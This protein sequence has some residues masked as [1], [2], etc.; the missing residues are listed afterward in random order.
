MAGGQNFFFKF[1][2]LDGVVYNFDILGSTRLEI[3]VVGPDG[4]CMPDVCVYVTDKSTSINVTTNSLGLAAVNVKGCHARVSVATIEYEAKVLDIDLESCEDG[5]Q[6]VVVSLTK[7][8]NFNIIFQ[9]YGY[10]SEDLT[11]IM[12]PSAHLLRYEYTTS[13]GATGFGTTVGGCF[14]APTCIYVNTDDPYT[15][16]LKISVSKSSGGNTINVLDVSMLDYDEDDDGYIISY[17]ARVT[18]P[19]TFSKIDPEDILFYLYLNVWL[20][21]Y[22][23]GCDNIICLGY[24]NYLLTIDYDG[25]IDY[26]DQYAVVTA[27]SSMTLKPM[28]FAVDKTLV[29]TNRDILVCLPLKAEDVSY[30]YP[31]F[32]VRV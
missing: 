26:I 12:I 2:K 14:T 18:I 6:K 9:Y 23:K 1:L 24:G 7:T 10:N 11:G 21:S 3:G 32:K 19:S 29:D 5:K 22:F 31:Y 13:S 15:E 4:T 28:G 20:E 25:Y 8:C 27:D 17:G 16:R 30:G